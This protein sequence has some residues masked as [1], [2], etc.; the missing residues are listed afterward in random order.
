MMD[1]G[2]A[3]ANPNQWCD[4]QIWVMTHEMKF[5]M[6]IWVMTHEMKFNMQI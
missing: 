2:A 3:V 6:Q 4:M 5:D 1:P